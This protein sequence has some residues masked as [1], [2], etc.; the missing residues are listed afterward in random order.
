MPDSKIINAVDSILT[1][2]DYQHLYRLTADPTPLKENCGTLCGSVCC[3]P[4]R[5]ND[6]GIYLFPGEEVMFNRRENWLIWEA[7]DPAEQLFPASWPDP[8]YFV[9]CTRPC[10]REARPL[11]C[12]F[13]PLAPHLQQDGS[14]LIIYETLELPYSCPLITSDLPLQRDFIETITKAWRIMLK[15][16]RIRDFVEEESRYRLAQRMPLQIIETGP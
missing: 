2:K 6:L 11:A 16:S 10:P 8:V 1:P 14:L 4:G 9:R 7:Q 15:D 12:R 5:D 13:F 3:Q